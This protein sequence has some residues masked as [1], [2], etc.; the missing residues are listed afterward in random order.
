MSKHTGPPAWAASNGAVRAAAGR[1]PD[2]EQER[3]TMSF[4]RLKVCM[5]TAAAVGLMASDAFAFG[6]RLLGGR[7]GDCCNPCQIASGTAGGCCGATAPAP[8]ACAPAAPCPA[9]AMTTIKV[10]EWVPEQVQQTRTVYR[11]E[12]KCETYTAYRT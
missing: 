7:S 3:A 1:V 10:T 2:S 5:L 8:A 6:G 9:P 11:N 4:R 12:T